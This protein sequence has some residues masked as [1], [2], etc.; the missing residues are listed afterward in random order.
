MGEGQLGA[1]GGDVVQD[2]DCRVT[3]CMEVNTRQSTGVR[4]EGQPKTDSNEGAAPSSVVIS[5]QA[6]DQ[7]EDEMSPVVIPFS[8]QLRSPYF[9]CFY[10]Y[11][12]LNAL[13]YSFYMTS[14]EN[15]FNASVNDLLG[16]LGPVSMI[17]SIILGKVADTWGVMSLVLFIITSG[18][19]MYVFALTRVEACYY[20]S[21]VF[22]CLYVSNFSGQMYAYMG[23]TFKTTDFGKVVGLTSA[24]GGLLSLLRIPLHDDLTVR[25]FKANYVYTC[26]LMLAISLF[27]FCLAL[28]LFFLKRKWPKAYL[29]P[30]KRPK[31]AAGVAVY[32]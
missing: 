31:A 4:A 3:S 6:L 23:D 7:S 1:G 27:C 14:A 16:I 28:Y 29:S 26:A 32:S 5:F 11:W 20:I 22:S 13:F 19:F 30:E 2:G 24:T 10:I 8:K 12:P 9:Y 25:I 18:V 17:P 21:A 15:L